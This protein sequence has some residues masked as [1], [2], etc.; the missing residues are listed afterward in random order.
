MR[1]EHLKRRNDIRDVFGKGK[2][3]S[4]QGTRLFVLMNN[5][6]HNRI[7]FTVSRA[8]KG[9]R[10]WNAVQ[11]NREKRL[12]REAFRLLKPRLCGGYDLILLVYP[13]ART[14]VS[15]SASFFG[16]PRIHQVRRQLEFLFTKAGLLR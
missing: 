1:D 16:R 6:P 15:R 9:S 3:Y 12:G 14:D 2:R 10:S 8:P 11:R 4:C 13:D 7:C 5:L